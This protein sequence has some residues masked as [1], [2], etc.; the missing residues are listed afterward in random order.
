MERSHALALCA[1]DRQCHIG[2]GTVPYFNS[3]GVRVRIFYLASIDADDIVV[4]GLNGYVVVLVAEDLETEGAVAV[5]GGL[6]RG[7]GVEAGY[8]AIEGTEHVW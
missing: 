7:V 1:P 5:A 4:P 2:A 8:E 3:K 6:R